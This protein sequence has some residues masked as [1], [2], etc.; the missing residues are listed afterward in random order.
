MNKKSFL[1]FLIIPLTL[2]SCKKGANNV[3]INALVPSYIRGVEG[4]YQVF[5]TYNDD[6]FLEDSKEV[7]KDI[8][9]L[10]YGSSCNNFDKE[11]I[12][13]YYTQM[14]FDNIYLSETYDN[15]G[16]HTINY[17]MGHKKIKDYNLVAISIRG[18]DY[19]QEW[20]SNLTL[21]SSGNHQGFEN[22]ALLIYDKL[23]SYIASNSYDNLKIWI[24]GYSRAGGVS[25][26]LSHLIMSKGEISV[27]QSNLFT[28]TFEA[29]RGLLKINALEYENVHNFINTADPVPLIAPAQYNIYRCGKDI[30]I[31]NEDIDAIVKKFD[32]KL[33][34]P[35]FTPYVSEVGKPD[36]AK[37]TLFDDWLINLFLG[38]RESMPLNLREQ[39]VS[40]VQDDLG[41]LMSLFFSLNYQEQNAFMGY[42]GE[43]IGIYDLVTIL[44]D[45]AQLYEKLK[46]YLVE[47]NISFD[48]DK[49]QKGCNTAVALVKSVLSS[50][51]GTFVSRS[52]NFYRMIDMHMPEV[53]YA[54]LLHYFGE[55]E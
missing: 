25:N 3:D 12:N 42:V 47:H 16:P 34:L 35:A 44:F 10:S 46:P 52:D 6:F 32:K 40:T 38:E 29:P 33:K 13:S 9:L 26:V 30:D 5:F 11:H 8:T 31:Y 24:T 50:L 41:Y 19:T 18:F 22:S 17:L 28:Y 7:S 49:F 15:P 39:F 2:V 43:N 23:K 20:V 54:L 45:N 55:L 37:E 48:D 27:D 4:H 51:I 36:Y 21:G 1:L 53:N 14:E